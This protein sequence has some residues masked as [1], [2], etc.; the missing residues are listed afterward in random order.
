[1][2][3][4]VH[5]QQPPALH[6]VEAFYETKPFFI[7]CRPQGKITHTA[8]GE[9]DTPEYLANVDAKYSELLAAYDAWAAEHA[10]LTY[11]IGDP[12]DRVVKFIK[13]RQ[14]EDS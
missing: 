14:G 4:I 2:Y 1:M 8:N 12:M 6:L 7:Y 9:W 5:D 13:I 10:H 11:R 3:G